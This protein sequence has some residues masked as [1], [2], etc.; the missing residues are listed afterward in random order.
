MKRLTL[1]LAVALL[2]WAAPASP[3]GMYLV[4]SKTD[5]IWARVGNLTAT[6]GGLLS[7]AAAFRHSVDST[8]VL[9][10]CGTCSR[11]IVEVQQ[12][13]NPNAAGGADTTATMYFQMKDHPDGVAANDSLAIEVPIRGPVGFTSAQTTPPV[14]TTR[15]LA[16]TMPGT[17]STAAWCEY[18]VQLGVASTWLFSGRPARRFIFGSAYYGP[19][20]ANPEFRWRVAGQVVAGTTP[21]LVFYRL[22][23]YCFRED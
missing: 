16:P 10:R 19:Y 6:T 9:L 15:I 2:A 22:S 14:D 7:E 8:G 20:V 11:Y 18:S 13:R 21:K 17:D 5:S 12:L 4:Y 3:K 1:L 23:I